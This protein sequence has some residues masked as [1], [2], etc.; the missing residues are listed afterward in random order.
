MNLKQICA[1]VML[2]LCSAVVFAQTTNSSGNW[3]TAAN[4]SSPSSVPINTSGTTGSPVSVVH[5]MTLN[6]NLSIST[7]VY[8]ISADV[9][10]ITGGTN[11]TLSMSNSSYSATQSIFDVKVGTIKIDGSVTLNNSTIFVRSGATLMTGAVTL[12]AASRVTIE[13]GGTWIVTGNFTD[14]NTA[15]GL[16]TLNG[17]LQISGS[18][19]SSAATSGVRIGPNPATTGQLLAGTT[20][21]STN[22]GATIFGSTNNATGT[23]TSGRALACGASGN[24][25][26]STISGGYSQYGACSFTTLT[27]SVTTGV[28]ASRIWEVS[29]TGPGSGFSSTGVT[30]ASFTSSPGQT[31]NKWYRVAYTISGC[32]GSPTLYSYPVL[33]YATSGTST[34]VGGISTDWNNGANWSQGTVPDVYTDVIIPSGTTFV[35]TSPGVGAN[36]KSLTVNS[37]ATLIASSGTIKLNCGIGLVNNGTISGSFNVE[38]VNGTQT[39]SGS[40]KTTI[41]RLK[42]NNCSFTANADVDLVTEISFAGA[43]NTVDF[44]G[45]SNDKVFAFMSTSQQPDNTARMAI[46]PSGTTLSGNVSYTRYTVKDGEHWS[47]F[48]VPLQNVPVSQFQVWHRVTGNFTGTDANY[49]NAPNN[50]TSMYDY[51]ETVITDGWDADAANNLNDGYYHFPRVTNTETF[52]GGRGYWYFAYAYEPPLSLAST[53]SWTVTGQPY[54][55]NV[56]TTI[57]HTNSSTVEDNDGWNFLGNPYISF[58]DLN[59]ENGILNVDKITNVFAIW[60]INDRV[61]KYWN[62]NTMIG[63]NEGS[64]YVA[65]GQGFFVKVDPA[66]GYGSWTLTFTEAAKV[67]NPE[68]GGHYRK[69]GEEN[70]LRMHLTK[71]ADPTYTE[72]SVIHFETGATNGHD[73]FY[74]VKCFDTRSNTT[75]VPFGVS[76]S[77]SG[78]EYAISA[79]ALSTLV[80]SNYSVNTFASP[81]G[82]AL[83]LEFEDIA[84]FEDNVG[85]K[86]ID[87]V[88]STTTAITSTNDTYTFTSVSN[89]ST[90]RF[91]LDFVTTHTVT[92]HSSA[93]VT[94]GGS[95][96]IT[97]T[98]FSTT[99]A[100]QTVQFQT[101]SGYVNGTI[102]AATTTQLTVTVPAGVINGSYARVVKDGFTKYVP[103]AL[104]VK[105]ILT[106]RHRTYN[107]TTGTATIYY[108]KNSGSWTSL[109]AV[110]NSGTCSS[111]TITNLSQNDVI[112]F[113][114][115][116]ASGNPVYYNSSTNDGCA[117]SQMYAGD[118]GARTGN[119]CSQRFATTIGNADYEVGLSINTSGH[120]SFGYNLL[121]CTPLTSV[122]TVYN[123]VQASTAYAAK[124]YYRVNGGSWTLG[125]SI[126]GTSVSNFTINSLSVGDVIDF[127]VEDNSTSASIEYWATTGTTPPSS[128]TTYAD[129]R[130]AGCTTYSGFSHTI[131]SWGGNSVAMKVKGSG[132]GTNFTFCAP[133]SYNLYINS[134]CQGSSSNYAVLYYR[135]NGGSWQSWTAVNSTACINSTLTG[136]VSGDFVEILAENASTSGAVNFL[137][138]TTTGTNCQSSGSSAMSNRA[139]DCSMTKYSFTFG[140]AHEYRSIYVNVS[141]GNFLECL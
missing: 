85:L 48:T 136:F 27:H 22:A 39:I 125:N 139:E 113:A 32:S 141:G 118:G 50:G 21:T 65:P 110:D 79:F 1:F 37:G 109:G 107:P 18:Y 68:G 74:D 44:D 124:T 135:V 115:E 105:V 12:T 86:L 20:I 17:L 36:I 123:T 140:S 42:V 47:R 45:S 31:V 82:T 54:V 112:T 75:P 7:G 111:Y 13:A 120:P 23:F 58:I 77:A 83:T 128:G 59:A 3:S 57:T 103:N 43:A 121:S 64:R 55:G 25:Y 53:A 100:N 10:D 95:Y 92:G 66:D 8:H 132:S 67:E 69:P 60:S 137:G 30:T 81:S 41:R 76:V 131:S 84:T 46:V 93:I 138:N 6:Q 35:A 102:T 29:T 72:E 87:N 15:T 96:V 19:T 88:L 14:N 98:G 51:D 24:A 38:F 33:Q 70:I 40:N 80:S 90:P 117:H 122:L 52:V 62:A 94:T 34:W 114:V 61:Y 56:G 127:A 133:A 116:D 134:T 101:A 49:P 2:L 89:Q 130:A 5:A 104:V 26:V 78:N 106:V 91:T 63:A 97:G 11:H 73:P 119:P 16:I 28:V 9:T 99:L 126:T 129:N 71:N 4:W 108:K